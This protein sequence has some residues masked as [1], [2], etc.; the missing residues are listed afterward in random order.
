MSTPSLDIVVE[1]HQQI[2]EDSFSDDDQGVLSGTPTVGEGL[3]NVRTRPSLPYF[4]KNEIDNETA[5][6]IARS[7]VSGGS[8]FHTPAEL[9]FQPAIRHRRLA[10]TRPALSIRY[11]G[12]RLGSYDESES[13]SESETES[14]YEESELG[15]RS[16]SGSRTKSTRKQRPSLRHAT[17][18]PSEPVN[19][20]PTTV[21]VPGDRVFIYG[22]RKRSNSPQS[23]PSVSETR[24]PLPPSVKSHSAFETPAR[25]IIKDAR[26][27][28]QRVSQQ[29][30]DRIVVGR[31]YEREL[32]DDSDENEGVSRSLLHRHDANLR[33]FRRPV[34]AEREVIAAEA[35]SDCET[36]A[37]QSYEM[38]GKRSTQDIQLRTDK[39]A[40][41]TPSLSGDMEGRTLQ[42]VPIETGMNELIIT[43]SREMESTYV[44]ERTSGRSDQRTSTYPS[45]AGRDA[46]DTSEIA[47]NSSLWRKHSNEK[48]SVSQSSPARE[49]VVDPPFSKTA[50]LPS[51]LTPAS[52]ESDNTQS[53]LELDE[54]RVMSPREEESTDAF[55]NVDETVSKLE[56]VQRK[57]RLIQEDNL[58]TLQGY[59]S[60]QNGTIARWMK[61][62]FWQRKSA[63]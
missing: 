47:S 48:P 37:D 38:A 5:N 21:V 18:T 26:S 22:N 33:Q 40:L 56:S 61:A 34:E 3:S 55:E 1:S 35:Y 50:P 2:T 42:L 14:E 60:K 53:R 27:I 52:N 59:L 4:Q 9:V 19:R 39:D 51:G 63:Y 8:G 58:A 16:P 57:S 11:S 12:D 36:Y 17:T 46:E 7:V 28:H 24:P 32:Y 25:V 29:A 45:A 10:S 31:N 62:F 44:S 23:C 13:E 30:S 41:A 6:R 20:R 49:V 15:R 54:S 43:G